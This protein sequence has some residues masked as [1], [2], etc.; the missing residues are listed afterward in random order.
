MTRTSGPLAGLAQVTNPTTPQVEVDDLDIALLRELAVDS[1][2]SQR[3]S[4]SSLA[5]WSPYLSRARSPPRCDGR[6]STHASPG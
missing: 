1:R 3:S 6:A 2:Q 5:G 4:F